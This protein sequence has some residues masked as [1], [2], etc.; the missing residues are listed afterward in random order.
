MHRDHVVLCAVGARINAA[1]TRALLAAGQA[2]LTVD[3]VDAALHDITEE[4][5][6]VIVLGP[7]M[8]ADM[9]DACE[10]LRNVD[11]CPDLVV[12]AVATDGAHGRAL[13][14]AGADDFFI[15][16]I[17]DDGLE[18]RLLV[19]GYAAASR[20]ARRC[21]QRDAAR[22][23]SESLTTTLES[24]GDG[25]I[26]TDTRGRITRMNPVAAKLSGWTKAD[27]AGRRLVDVLKFVDA[28]SRAAVES[29]VVRTL[30]DG[31]TASLPSHCLLVRP[32]GAEIPVGDNCAP[33]KG[34]G[35][36]ATG[37]VLVFR[38]L[39]PQRDAEAKHALLQE[40]LILADRL[41]SVG[42]LAAGVAHEINNPL[43][44]IAANVDMALEEVRQ[45]ADAASSIRVKE[46]EEMLNGARQGVE[47]VTTIVRGIKTFSRVEEE[48]KGIIDL[49]PLL[50]LSI[51]I[52]EGEVRPRARLVREYDEVPLV[53]ADRARLGQVFINLLVNAAHAFSEDAPAANE[54]RVVAK[55]D[56]R[57]RAVVEIR[58]TGHGIPTSMLGRVFDPFFTTKD[59][60][61]GT[62]LG[63]SISRT[64][65]TGLG[66]EISVE[67]E[68]GR[69]S[70]FRIV[71][72]PAGA[73]ATQ[74]PLAA[75]TMESS[76]ARRAIV[77]VVDDEPSVGLVI[78]RALR[79]HDVTV[80]ASA[81]AA[82]D[83][84]ASGKQFDVVLSDLMMPGMS[85]IDLYKTVARTDPKLASRI[86]FVTGGAFT[87]E[88]NAFLDS[89]KNPRVDKPFT[90]QQLRDA[91]L[92]FVR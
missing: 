9:R 51:G 4:G 46:V 76:A 68:V 44:A 59:I 35:G 85:G 73:G 14:A 30:R 81:E 32:D 70:V 24:I 80:V 2:V 26:A 28:G 62:G 33:I 87:P 20:R 74:V 8:G 60:G 11:S 12:V 72:P 78:H 3:T 10:R 36:I 65:V 17:G 49:L 83:V 15:E 39:T 47:R 41:A 43:S 69:G 61:R 48:Q 45:L 50:D 6:S 37:A 90:P 57:G 67:S 34:K 40:Q 89:V 84:L 82:L 55:T 88:A 53:F 1:A 71:L 42:T 86:V 13:L 22:D 77:L 27:A 5:A 29:P 64:I 54:I 91:V 66:G 75:P 21:Q 92:R 63:L 52:A 7:L 31:V 19:A 23:D 56:A 16:R 79:A 38:D 58:D 18:N 25:V